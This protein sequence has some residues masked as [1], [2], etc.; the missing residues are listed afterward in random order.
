M[1]RSEWS[2]G[3]SLVG[4]VTG[5]GAGRSGIRILVGTRNLFIFAK[6]TEL[7]GGQPSPLFSGHHGGFPDVTL[8]AH[9]NV[10]SRKTG[11]SYTSAPTRLNGVSHDKFT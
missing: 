10:T 2:L 7:F 9:L 5:R 6:R 3:V 1:F 8:A 11:R 4:I